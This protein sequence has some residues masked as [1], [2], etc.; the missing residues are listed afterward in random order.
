MYEYEYKFR[1]EADSAQW[2]WKDLDISP[3]TPILCIQMLPLLPFPSLSHIL[4]SS[5]TI[6]FILFTFF[7]SLLSP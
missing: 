1:A 3:P 7:L 4:Y 2:Y 5:F 6:P